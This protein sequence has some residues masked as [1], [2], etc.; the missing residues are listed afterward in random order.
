MAVI[1][2]AK[3]ANQNRI[4]RYCSAERASLGLVSL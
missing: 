2:E 3:V 4:E 1:L